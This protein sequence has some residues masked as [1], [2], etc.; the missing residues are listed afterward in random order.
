MQTVIEELRAEI[1]FNSLAL[2]TLHEI[3]TKTTDNTAPT[4]EYKLKINDRTKRL[5]VRSNTT[6]SGSDA[7]EK[8]IQRTLGTDTSMT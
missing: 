8:R 2:N 4:P 6:E 1:K 5:V 3:R 7:F